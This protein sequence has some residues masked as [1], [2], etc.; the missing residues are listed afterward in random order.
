M[1]SQ[2]INRDMM[3]ICWTMQCTHYNKTIPSAK[4]KAENHTG[5]W[6]WNLLRLYNSLSSGTISVWQKDQAEGFV[7]HAQNAAYHQEYYTQALLTVFQISSDCICT[8][9]NKDHDGDNQQENMHDGH[10][11]RKNRWWLCRTTGRTKQKLHHA[12]ISY[13]TILTISQL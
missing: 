13:S 6:N 9:C 11:W 7:L 8:V 4:P 12:L 10:E 1:H 3:R 5:Q 2:D